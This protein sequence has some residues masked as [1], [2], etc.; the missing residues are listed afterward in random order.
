MPTRIWFA[1]LLLLACLPPAGAIGWGLSEPRKDKLAERQGQYVLNRGFEDFY[2]SAF[3]LT[4]AGRGAPRA[5]NVA[6][7]AAVLVDYDVVIFGEI[8]RHPGVHLQE[9]KLLRA[10]VERDPHWILSLEQFE[11]DAQGVVNDY[12]AGR[13][14]ERALIDKGHAWDNYPTSYRPLLLYA[15]EHQLPV[16]AAEAPGWSIGCIGQYGADILD[17]FTPT[18]RSWVARDLHVTSD[19]YRDKYME[20]QSGSATHGGGGATTPEARLKSERSFTAQVARDD[21]MAESIILARQQYPGRKVLHLTG[22]FHA[23]GFLGTVTRLRLRDPSL[24]IAVIDSVEVADPKAPGFAAD[25]L[26]E[27]TALLLVHPSPEEFV[28][29]EDESDFIRGIIAK[30][31]ASPCKYTPPGAAAS[32]EAAPP[33]GSAPRAAPVVEAAPRAAQASP[34]IEHALQVRLQPA[35]HRV[36]VHDRLQIPAA[37]VDRNFSFL[38]NADLPARITSPG[39]WLTMVRR[40]VRAGANDPDDPVR[41]NVYR[42]RGAKEHH[43]LTLDLAYQGLIDHPVQEHGQAY[44]RGSGETPGLIEDRGVYLAGSS[45]WVPEVDGTLLRDRLEIDLPAGWKSVSEGVRVGGG[46]ETKPQAAA[47]RV[48]EVWEVT[49]PTEQV[50]LAAA[51]FT[52]YRRDAGAVKAYAFLRTPDEAL[53]DR[54][55][56]ATAQYLKMYDGL[57]GDYPYGKFA[58]VENFWETGYGMPSFTLLGEQIIR[59]PFILTSSYPH[60]LLHNW[61]G[62][63]VF[64]DVSGGNW[65]EGLTAYL[66]DE[67]LAE[68]RGEGSPH[69]RD[70]LQRVT[71]F[72]TPENDFP[73]SQF[74][75]RHDAITEAI[76]YGKTAMVWNMLRER[77]GDAAFVASLQAFY[78]E[79]RFRSA[80]Y[81]DIRRSFE[82]V[83][84]RDLGPFFRQWVTQKGVPELKL[85]QSTRSGNEVTVRL[86]QVQAPPWFALD[87]PVAIYTASGVEIHSI[88]MPT[89]RPTA[90]GS[91]ALPAPATRIDVDPQFQLY[92]RL[93][94]LETPP[95]LSKAF[96]ASQVLIVVPAAG[97]GTQYSGLVSAWT[98]TGVEVVDDQSL[99]SLPRDRPVWII[100]R[101]NRFAAAVGQALGA[102]G[103]ALDAGSLRVGGTTYPA[104]AK[105]LVAAVR[106]P[107]NPAM[108]LVYLSAPTAAAA[109]GLARKL[110]HYGKYSWLVFR[111]DAPD[112]EAKG[113]WPTE[114]SPLVQVFESQATLAALPVRRALAEL[115][116]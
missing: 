45:H 93:S 100:G 63:G 25:L 69:R 2:D 1:G 87:V 50:H 71:D 21:T 48:G 59:F 10:L 41:V 105:S 110:P 38:L 92:R 24:K 89:D 13:I 58:L 74:R 56:A 97:A 43:D 85:D 32:P 35:A 36:E 62:N 11:R 86:A 20:F 107:E 73:P 84:G 29:G 44:A 114:Q 16:I 83:T 95:A 46:S 112:N 94:A 96:G 28:E 8:H 22:T 51:R 53:A 116:P 4:N 31:K 52:E 90:T 18:E 7:L 106:N 88:A 49:T 103:A 60:E 79:N 67:L 78:R 57:I 6:E 5:V 72:V 64:V 15:R 108:V 3:V 61:W 82:A 80:G 40:R 91:F 9:L 70:I 27:A 99:S 30:R 12:L 109:D 115:P 19:A 14:G 68:Q 54:Y 34:V 101:S 81:D 37:L 66:A 76:G 23:E 113:E 65:C 17:Q 47:D 42:V 55:L 75:S 77:V 33:S 102:H 39:L 111:G 98:R 26:T 104:D